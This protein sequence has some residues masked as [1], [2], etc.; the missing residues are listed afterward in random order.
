M[1][2]E[3]MFKVTSPH[4]SV[5][6]KVVPGHFATSHAHV[7]YYIDITTLKTRQSE[8]AEVAHEL[9]ARYMSNTL[10]DTIVCLDGTQVIGGFLAEAFSRAGFLSINAHQTIYVVAPETDSAGQFFFRD[11]LLLALR[12]KHVLLLTAMVTTGISLAQ[13]AECVAYYGGRTVGAAAIFSDIDTVGEV[14]VQHLFSSKD[15]PNYQA[16]THN[17]CPYC[18][19]GQKLEALVNSFGYSAL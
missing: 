9:A 18:K 16:F 15:V 5:P 11:N 14:S 4:S 7:N 1:L 10:V 6:L 12:G 2:E 13:A 19:A 17:D 3:R 8:A